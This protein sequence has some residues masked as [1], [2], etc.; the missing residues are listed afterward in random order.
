MFASSPRF[1][2]AVLVVALAALAAPGASAQGNPD[3]PAA[4]DLIAKYVK[5]VGGEAWKSHKSARMKATMEVPAA[6][7]SAEL[8][9]AQI[10]PNR[11]V[12]KTNM[13]GVGEMKTGYN[14]TVAW[15]IDPMQ[16]PRVLTG[17]QEEAMRDNADPAASLRMSASIANSE[18]VEKT[19]MNNQE[20]FKVKHT[21][22][23]GRVAHDCYATSNGLLVATTTTQPTAMGDVEVTH[24]PTEYKEMNGMK[25]P[26][27]VTSHTMGQ[28]MT[29]KITS[30]EWDTVDPKELELPVEIKALVEKKP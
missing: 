2:R 23:S 28:T 8:E 20:C 11:I 4:K 21:F 16:G 7:I 6:G 15:S 29:M 12:E 14:G 5:A 22:K 30:F 25:R 18:T 27:L 24:F 26:T 1:A 13:P 19:T 9:V 3:L 10:F 17:A